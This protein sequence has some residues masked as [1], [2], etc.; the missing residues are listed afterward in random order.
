MLGIF[1][2]HLLIGYDK[3][4]LKALLCYVILYQLTQ[5]YKI[6]HYDLL[7]KFYFYEIIS[8]PGRFLRNITK[9]E[10]ISMYRLMYH[11]YKN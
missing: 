7:F 11:K 4:N 8:L 2:I 3:T 6:K 5:I 10:D 9:Q 1:N